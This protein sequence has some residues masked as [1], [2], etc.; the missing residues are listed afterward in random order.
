MIDIRTALRR[1]GGQGRLDTDETLG[2]AG[3]YD[4][5]PMGYCG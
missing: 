2:V 5:R 1:R 3:D 4:P